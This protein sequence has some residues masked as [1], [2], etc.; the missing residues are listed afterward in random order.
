MSAQGH[1]LTAPV[2]S[3][4]VYIVLGLSF[5]LISIT[6]LLSRNN[7]PH[8]GDNIH[9]LPHGGAYRDGTKAILYN[10]PNFGSRTSLN[11]SKNAAFAAVLLLS[12]LIYGSRCLS[13]RNHLCACGNNHSS[14]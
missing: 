1:R 8:V 10:S 13:Q 3:E 12:L 9:S 5:A 11:N 7:L 6:F 2:N 4:K 14:N